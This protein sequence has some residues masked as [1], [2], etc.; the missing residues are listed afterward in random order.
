MLDHTAAEDAARGWS[1]PLTFTN[2]LTLDPLDHSDYEPLPT[3]ISSRSTR[4]T[5]RRPTHG[6]AAS[7]PATTRTRTTRTSSRTRPEYQEYARPGDGVV[8]PYS[9]Y[10]HALRAYHGDQAVMVTELGVPSSLGVAHSGPLGRDQGNHSEEE[11]LAM[12]AQML[13]DLKEEGYA[14]GSCSSGSTSGSSSRGTPS[15]SSSP[16][17]GGSSGRT[18]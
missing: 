1:R 7:S 17:T 11:A 15:I 5:S 3:R 16:A 10:L 8:D 4:P 9:G 18:T 14:G 13:R 6:R 12:D 2:W